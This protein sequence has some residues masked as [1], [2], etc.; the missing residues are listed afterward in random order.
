L[1]P[2]DKGPSFSNGM[3][4]GDFSVAS[5]TLRDTEIYVQAIT[6][7]DNNTSYL[8]D[9]FYNNQSVARGAIKV[10]EQFHSFLRAN[11]IGINRFLGLETPKGFTEKVSDGIP[12]ISEPLYISHS[13]DELSSEILDKW[14]LSNC[15]GNNR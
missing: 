14:L 5:G 6:S 8:L 13:S 11:H 12:G 2:E 4:D 15:G 10:H 3:D 9:K 1:V 7:P